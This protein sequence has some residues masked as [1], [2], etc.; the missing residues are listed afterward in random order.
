MIFYIPVIFIFFDSF[1]LFIEF[2][3]GVTVSPHH[4][5]QEDGDSVYTRAI[6]GDI[7]QLLGILINMDRNMDAVV[8]TS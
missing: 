2:V 3:K 7:C 5:W 8:A 4:L 1:I 6:W